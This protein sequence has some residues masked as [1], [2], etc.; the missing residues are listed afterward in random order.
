MMEVLLWLFYFNEYLIWNYLTTFINQNW[1]I[2]Q[3][4]LKI[5]NSTVQKSKITY[6]FFLPFKYENKHNII[7]DKKKKW[8]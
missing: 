8:E 3:I 1:I 6:I 7:L 5:Q 4:H 2:L